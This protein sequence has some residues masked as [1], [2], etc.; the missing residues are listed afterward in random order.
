MLWK[1][2]L[3][4]SPHGNLHVLILKSGRNR[5]PNQGEL[6]RTLLFT[7]KPVPGLYHDQETLT[8]IEAWPQLFFNQTAELIEYMYRERIASPLRGHWEQPYCRPNPASCA[9]QITEFNRHTKSMNR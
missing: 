7:R 3:Q 1:L 6:P 4:F 5:T 8:G 2:R 9:A